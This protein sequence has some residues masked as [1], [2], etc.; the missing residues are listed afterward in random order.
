MDSYDLL[1]VNG[2]VV[3]AADVGRYD[4]A[5]KDGKI[6]LLA[7]TGALA[8]ASA[9]RIIDAEGGYVMVGDPLLSI[10][11]CIDRFQPGGIDAHVHLEEPALFG[12]RGKSS[13]TFESG[14]YAARSSSCSC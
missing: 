2:T 6:A 13:D 4:I 14:W 10:R 5:V 1:V 11:T 8:G 12:G 9:S 3:T 7:P